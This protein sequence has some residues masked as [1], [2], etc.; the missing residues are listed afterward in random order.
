AQCTR[1]QNQ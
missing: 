1:L